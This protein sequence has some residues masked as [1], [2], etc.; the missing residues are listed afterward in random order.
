MDQNT[1]NTV[2]FPAISYY[3]NQQNSSDYYTEPSSVCTISYD[4]NDNP[5]I[6]AWFLTSISQPSL[7]TLESYTFNAV[8]TYWNKIDV[9]PQTL[10]ST[11][12]WL[13]LTPSQASGIP[14]SLIPH[15]C[16]M[17]QN[18]V[19]VQWNAA[20]IVWLPL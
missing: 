1:L 11:N 2:F 3:I 16:I 20:S 18:G 19:L 7:S 6:S 15:G 5:Y 17:V 9:Y 13:T 14:T 4:D 10:K 12:S 8:N